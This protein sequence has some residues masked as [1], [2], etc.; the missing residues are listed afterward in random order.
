MSQENQ[1][2]RH[3][4]RYIPRKGLLAF[5]SSQFGEVLNISLGGMRYRSLLGLEEPSSHVN[6]HIGLLNSSKGDSLDQLPCHLV[7]T[8]NALPVF[9]TRNTIIREA[10]VEFVGLSDEQKRRLQEL[11]SENAVGLA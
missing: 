11:L 9:P 3:Y 2:R 5:S 7:S 1:E 6:Q 8:T 10:S 4:P